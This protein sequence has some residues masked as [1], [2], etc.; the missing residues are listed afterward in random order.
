MKIGIDRISFYSSHYFVDLKT[1]ANERGID[2]DK[3]YT[4]IGQEKMAVPSPDEDV[5]KY[6]NL[7]SLLELLVT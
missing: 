1:I 2:A 4:G 6:V 3:F 7:L 5:L